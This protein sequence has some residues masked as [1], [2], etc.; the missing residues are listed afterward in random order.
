ME[1]KENEEY[2]SIQDWKDNKSEEEWHNTMLK[3][4]NRYQSKTESV[5]TS[6]RLFQHLMEVQTNKIVFA[7][8][9]D[10]LKSIVFRLKLR[11]LDLNSLVDLYNKY[12]YGKLRL[13]SSMLVMD[14]TKKEFQNLFAILQ[15]A[16]LPQMSLISLWNVSSLSID[17]INNFLQNCLPQKLIAFSFNNLSNTITNI[18]PYYES[19]RKAVKKWTQ[20]LQLHNLKMSGL[21][22][23]GI[24]E[25]ASHCEKVTV[26]NRLNMK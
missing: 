22:F 6:T 26:N 9:Q 21:E 25:S 8:I 10:E 1:V 12:I 23:W 16:V 18:N 7:R 24:I 15:D 13:V 20:E 3:L 19:L 17:S 4:N 11:S 14:L 5:Y 2:E